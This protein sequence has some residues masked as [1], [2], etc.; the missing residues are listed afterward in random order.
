M[1]KQKLQPPTLIKSLQQLTNDYDKPQLVSA[2][3]HLKS[4]LSWQLL[5]TALM[6]EYLNNVSYSLDKAAKTGTQIEAAYY[7]GIAQTQYDTANSLI[8]KYIDLLSEKTIVTENPRPE[9]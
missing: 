5:R 6:Q 2:L 3:Q 1:R 4:D 9:E 8:D 7:A